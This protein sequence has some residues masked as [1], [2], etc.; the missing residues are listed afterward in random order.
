MTLQWRLYGWPLV[1]KTIVDV[2]QGG[3]K[4]DR[5]LDEPLS[6]KMGDEVR[7]LE[8]RRIWAQCQRGPI[9]QRWVPPIECCY[10]C[11]PSA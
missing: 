7:R 9:Y 2:C 4:G 10:P 8:Y 1:V 6:D 3:N 11:K 5:I